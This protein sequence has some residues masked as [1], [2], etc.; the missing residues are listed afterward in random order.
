MLQQHAHCTSKKEKKKR[1]EKTNKQKGT[2][3]QFDQSLFSEN[4]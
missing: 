4:R 3:A 2:C 1:R